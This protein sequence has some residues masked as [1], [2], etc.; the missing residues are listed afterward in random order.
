[1]ILEYESIEKPDF[2]VWKDKDADYDADF[3]MSESMAKGFGLHNFSA[4][5]AKEIKAELKKKKKVK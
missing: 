5:L 1:M 2:Y 4:Y 3:Y